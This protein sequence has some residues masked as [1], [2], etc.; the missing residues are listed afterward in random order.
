MR[1]PFRTWLV[2]LSLLW[3]AAVF[4]GT[5][6][7]VRHEFSAGPSGTGARHWPVGCSLTRQAGFPTLVISL[8]PLCPCSQAS[9]EEL[10]RLIAKEHGR[11][12][13]FA[14]FVLPETPAEAWQS[15]PLWK[16]VER[17]PGVHVLPDPS[18]RLSRVF[19]AA[20]SGEV[21]LYDERGELRFQGGL[22]ASRGHS[23]SSRGSAALQ[24]LISGR[25]AA[26]HTTPVFG[27]PVFK[28]N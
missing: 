11:V 27:C 7:L 2:G 23:G 25:R 5:F 17:I 15:A 28:S 24:D 6:M 9:V 12:Q 4:A 22:T 13:V 20:T 21:L 18:G 8:H 1:L 10:S 16:Q 14:L 3:A 19:G 26:L